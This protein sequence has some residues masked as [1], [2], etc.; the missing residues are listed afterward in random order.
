MVASADC[1]DCNSVRDS[2]TEPLSYS[3][4]DSR[5]SGTVWDKWLLFL[6]AKCW[7]NLL[8]CGGYLI[9][10]SSALLPASQ[11]IDVSLNSPHCLPICLIHFQGHWT[12]VTS[13]KQVGEEEKVK[14]SDIITIGSGRRGRKRG[15]NTCQNISDPILNLLHN[16]FSQILLTWTKHLVGFFQ[17]TSNHL[18][19]QFHLPPPNPGGTHS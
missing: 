14:R 17:D 18:L 7:Y 13:T 1:L 4:L 5:F 12:Q 16:K 2:E 8:C 15:E 9:Y 6:A 11:R 19:P 3:L 10:L